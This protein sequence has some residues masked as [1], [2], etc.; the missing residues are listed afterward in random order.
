MT[1]KSL[2]LL[3]VVEYVETKQIKNFPEM[4]T[5]EMSDNNQPSVRQGWKSLLINKKQERSLSLIFVI[6]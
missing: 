6:F 4:V 5:N 3:P 2:K 1:N